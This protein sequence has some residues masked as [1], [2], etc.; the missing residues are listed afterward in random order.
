MAHDYDYEDM[1]KEH[2]LLGILHRISQLVIA[3]RLLEDAFRVMLEESSQSR[4]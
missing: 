1:P 2:D 4:R 3:S